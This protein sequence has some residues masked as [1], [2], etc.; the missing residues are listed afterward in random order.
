MNLETKIDGFIINR[1]GVNSEYFCYE[2]RYDKF[3][4][5][6]DY[7]IIRT[8]D[9]IIYIKNQIIH[10]FTISSRIY[11]TDFIDKITKETEIN[12]DINKDIFNT[13]K[14]YINCE[15]LA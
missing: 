6:N 11:K 10:S 3:N 1:F 14:R 7:K 9:Y 15:I 5:Y 2:I 12:I 4:R 13:L 8:A